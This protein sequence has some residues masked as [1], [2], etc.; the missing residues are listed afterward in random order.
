MADLRKH[1]AWYFKGFVVGGEV[2]AALGRVSTLDELDGL[3]QLIE[4]S[5]DFPFERDAAYRAG[6]KA[7]RAKSHCRKAGSTIASMHP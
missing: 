1:M 4:P 7:A 2:R 6:G 3:L 5:Q